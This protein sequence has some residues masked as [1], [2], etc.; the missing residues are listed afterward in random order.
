MASDDTIPFDAFYAN[1]LNLRDT[2]FIPNERR[3]QELSLIPDDILDEIRAAGL[4]GISIP[5]HYGGRGYTME[6]Q[7][8]THFVLCQASAVFR[9]QVS[10]TIGLG[11]QPILDHGTEDQKQRYLPAL[12]QGEMTA[13]FA[14]T[15][16][17]AGSDAASI[18]TT[19]ARH[20][21]GW[22]LNGTKRYITNAPQADVFLVMARTGEADSGAKGI[23]AFLVPATTSGLSVGEPD[24]KMG[25]AGSQTAE[26]YFDG[27][28][29]EGD[30][31]LGSEGNGFK[32]ALRGINHARLHVAATCV[33]QAI[34]LTKEAFS[35]AHERHQFGKAIAEHQSI[36]AMLADCRAETLAARSMVLET[37]RKF[38]AGTIDV[39]DVACSKYFAS[40]M[41]SRV[42]D[43]ALQIHGGRG[44]MQ[45]SD[46][47][48]LYRDTRVFRIFE[49]TSQIQQ[50][51]IA[52]EMAKAGDV[53][54]WE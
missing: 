38:D 21:N 33:G 11:S 46:V 20:G 9:A 29:A 34:R 3:V 52:K 14:L 16:P 19:A 44:Y 48:W 54:L 8:K 23:S 30:S 7:V 22:L 51:L 41:V 37:A 35:Y 50:G 49:G 39:G 36:Q 28:R 15:E 47:E 18:T 12:A 32:V 6:E 24:L 4:F 40:E 53:G 43:R 10:T 42:A 31:L 13:A 45:S 25:Q 2:V 26:V 17:D 27:C 1:L 5:H